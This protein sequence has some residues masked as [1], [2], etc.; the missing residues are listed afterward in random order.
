MVRNA[1]FRIRLTAASLRRVF[2]PSQ[3]L[4]AARRRV[5]LA[6]CA[7]DPGSPVGTSLALGGPPQ[8]GGTARCVDVGP[9]REGFLPL[10]MGAASAPLDVTASASLLGAKPRQAPRP[11]VRVLE[12]IERTVVDYQVPVFIRLYAWI[13][14]LQTWCSLRFDDHRGLEPG[15]LRNSETSLTGVLTSSKTHGPDK[16]IQR[17]PI[18][19]DKCYWFAVPNWCDVGFNLLQDIAPYER[20]YLLPSPGHNHA[21]IREAEMSGPRDHD[22][23]SQG[24]GRRRAEPALCVYWTPHS[25]RAFMA[26][27]CA[28]LGV[29]KAERNVLGRW[30]QN[31]SDTYVRL[32]RTLVQKL[33]L[34]VVSVIR[35][36]DDI[37]AVLGEGESLQELDSF[38]EKRGGQPRSDPAAAHQTGQDSV[39]RSGSFSSPGD[40]AFVGAGR[41]TRRRNGAV[42]ICSRGRDRRGCS[43]A[44]WPPSLCQH[45]GIPGPSVEGASRRFLFLRGWPFQGETLALV[46]VQLDG[47]WGGLLR[48]LVQ[49]STHAA[50]PR[51]RRSVQALQCSLIQSSASRQW[52]R[53]GS[54]HRHRL[55]VVCLLVPHLFPLPPSLS[56]FRLHLLFD[57][58]GLFVSR[59]SAM[60]K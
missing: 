45:Q 21:G 12:T 50:R 49:R 18:F 9:V 16:R 41:G 25:P 29:A 8:D 53:H 33:Q 34:L 37:G 56:S 6:L 7:D 19:L 39:S 28:A 40:E 17:K 52:L 1:E 44:A 36:R 55:S 32:Q 35:S 13:Y 3:F 48:V 38:L 4:G 22:K 51:V 30:A 14:L 20:D 27:C 54:F 2:L 58:V 42:G 31:Q 57:R 26:T 15:L 24:A 60:V 46:E 5:S 11:L 43:E 10:G 47:P 23:P 59:L